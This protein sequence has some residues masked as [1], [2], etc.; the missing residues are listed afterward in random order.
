M[1]LLLFVASEARR[2]DELGADERP[3]RAGAAD[4]VAN[5][6]ERV[7]RDL[8]AGPAAPI[9]HRLELHNPTV[10]PT[11]VTVYAKQVEDRSTTFALEG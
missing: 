3:D 6:V 9:H 1:P 5:L 10:D 7:R 4:L 2:L 8:P 11:P